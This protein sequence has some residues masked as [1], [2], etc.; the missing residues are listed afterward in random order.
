MTDRFC[1]HLEQYAQ[2]FEA[3]EAAYFAC[4]EQVDVILAGATGEAMDQLAALLEAWLARD[5]LLR[6]ALV[7]L[8]AAGAVRI[9]KRK[10]GSRNGKRKGKGKGKGRPICAECGSKV[11]RL[12]TPEWH[13]AGNGAAAFRG[14]ELPLTEIEFAAGEAV[15]SR[16]EEVGV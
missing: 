13:F 2:V 5:R 8:V 7:E 4:N 11:P 15:A 1:E 9:P 3:A 6:E 16:A 10:R 14:R 12:E